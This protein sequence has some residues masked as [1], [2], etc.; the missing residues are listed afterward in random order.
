MRCQVGE[1]VG[2]SVRFD[3]QTSAG[4]RIKFMTD[5]MLLRE[6]LMDPLLTRYSII[7]VDEAHERS[8]SSDILLGLLKKIVKQRSEL[9]IIVSSATIEADKIATFFSNSATEHQDCRIIALSGR[10]FSVDTQYLESPV[11]DYITSAVETA[12]SIHKEESIG[13]ILIFLTGRDDIQKALQLLS[14]YSRKILPAQ[15]ALQPL[16]LYAGLDHDSQ[17]YVFSPAAENTRKVI[18]STN[19]AEASVTIDGIVYVIDCGLVKLRTY[20][21]ITNIETL[22]KVPVSQAS[23]TQRAGRAGR[24][25]AGKCYRLYTSATFESL[26]LTTSPEIQRTNLAPVVLQ[27]KALGIENIVQFPYLTP[28][29][30]KL[31]ARALEQLHSLGALDD[32]AKMT[33]PHGSRMA[34]LALPPMM[35]K[36]LLAS[37]APEFDCLP[38]MLSIAAMC[39][40]QAAGN[41]GGIWF[42]HEGQANAADLSRRKFAAEEGDHLTYLNMFQAFMSKGQRDQRWCQQNH[43]NQ[44]ALMKAVS[45][46]SQLHRYLSNLGINIVNRD[47]AAFDPSSTASNDI[48]QRILRCLTTGYFAN[49]ARMN[50]VDGTF[51][52]VSAS[53]QNSVTMFPHPTSVMFNRKVDYCLFHELLETGDKIYIKDISKIEKKWLTE[54]AGNYY[55]INE[56]R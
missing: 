17:I 39:S 49:V 41:A 20:N 29:P 42:S 14:D 44:K 5:G 31:L 25:K 40:L 47:S 37:A 21:P 27:L 6:A 18:L 24:T 35:A 55:Q 28:P 46:R 7:M 16:P 54:L 19:V 12:I 30:S 50:P 34:E 11:D 23:A 43:V 9:R 1:D 8:L 33:K 32:Y 10:T 56:R 53:K 3:D 13:D 2:Y 36:A 15:Q 45:I 51:R 48:S 4:T 26:P 52:P 22:T 38:E